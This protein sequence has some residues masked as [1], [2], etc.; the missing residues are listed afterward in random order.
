MYVVPIQ[1][2]EHMMTS[3]LSRHQPNHMLF[4]DLRL[5]SKGRSESQNWKKDRGFQLG[6]ERSES[7]KLFYREV[8]GQSD[9]GD[10]NGE[11]EL[12][13]DHPW[14]WEE[15]LVA[16]MK[17]LERKMAKDLG[18]KP[19]KAGIYMIFKWDPRLHAIKQKTIKGKLA[20]IQVISPSIEVNSLAQSC[21]QAN[22]LE[23]ELIQEGSFGI[24]SQ[25]DHR[26]RMG[27]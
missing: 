24:E 10:Y 20:V 23:R 6:F 22:I 14:K 4:M 16:R 9:G 12:L 18:K 26:L 7:V 8:K 2:I 25:R 13:A 15:A 1:A 21:T 3:L 27:F 19:S 5:Y 17:S 11:W